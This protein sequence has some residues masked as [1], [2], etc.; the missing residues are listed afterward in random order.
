[1]A[2]VVNNPAPVAGNNDG[3]GFLIGIVLLIAFIAMLLYF[4]L[5]IIRN[6]GPVQVNVPAPQVVMPDK[7]DV[8]VTQPK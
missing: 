5:P 4:G 1:M 2:T 8:N 3:N 7:V 6:M